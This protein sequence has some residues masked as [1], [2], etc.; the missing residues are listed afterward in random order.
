VCVQQTAPAGS[1]AIGPPERRPGRHKGPDRGLPAGSV[2]GAGEALRARPGHPSEEPDEVTRP[3]RKLVARATIRGASSSLVW[4]GLV[5]SWRARGMAQGGLGRSVWGARRGPGRGHT[6]PR[7]PGG[8]IGVE[9]SVRAWDDRR[10]VRIRGIL[11]RLPDRP[12]PAWWAPG[13]AW[14]ARRLGGFRDGCSVMI[15]WSVERSARLRSAPA[16]LGVLSA[17]N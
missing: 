14:R 12:G 5:G 1:S 7:R 13:P 15:P 2:R 11:G 3:P 4:T 9:R 16:G 17:R 10:G 6:G 8:T